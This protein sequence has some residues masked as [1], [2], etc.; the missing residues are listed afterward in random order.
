MFT[1]TKI[2]FTR[3]RGWVKCFDVTEQKDGNVCGAE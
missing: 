1:Y 3:V 2:Y